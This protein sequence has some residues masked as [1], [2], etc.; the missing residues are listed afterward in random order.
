[1]IDLTVEQES[2][3]RGIKRAQEQNIIIPTFA[4]M[5]NP[6]LIPEAIKSSLRDIGLWDLTPENLFRITWKN[7]PIPQGGVFGGINFIR[8]P[9]LSLMPDRHGFRSWQASAKPLQ[10]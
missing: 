4:Q 3:Q 8:L 1:M 6:D 10:R 9:F 5:K 7:E 2:R